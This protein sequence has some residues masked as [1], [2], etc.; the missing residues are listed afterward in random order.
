MTAPRVMRAG[1][2]HEFEVAYG[3]PEALPA[4]EQVLWQGSPEWRALALQAFHARQVALYFLFI[5]GL[6]AA[7][8]LSDGGT[9]LQAAIAVLWLAPV[10]VFAVGM[11]LVMARLSSH[12]TVYTVT[13]K[14]VVMR[15]GIVLTLTFNLPLRALTGAGLR[16]YA[17][18]GTGDLPLLLDKKQKIAFFHLWPHVRPWRVAQPEPMLRAVKDAASVARLLQSAWSAETGMSASQSAAPIQA[19]QQVA[20]GPDQS[21]MLAA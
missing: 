20:K 9:A 13:N 6:R 19:S 12:T 1:H 15:V 2:E 5:L 10:A 17:Q 21:T 8:V 14:R 18:L 4:G 11:L 3:L 16:E 7:F